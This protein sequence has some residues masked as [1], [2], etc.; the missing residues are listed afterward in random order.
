MTVLEQLRTKSLEIRKDPAKK[1]LAPSVM[2]AISEIEKIGKNA[3]N[4]ATTD[5]EAIKVIQK[6]IITL[7]D[8]I[9]LATDTAVIEKFAAEHDLLRGVLPQMA[10]EQDVR[11]FLQ[12]SYVD[13]KPNK[14]DV[15]K[16]LRFK[17]GAKI[18]MKR[19]GEIVK[20]LYDI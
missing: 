10:S 13:V 6:I 1:W 14:G 11:G 9:S 7:E 20:E 4:R 3:G 17:F 15:M 19:A 8:N 16:T 18:D 12:E 2:F 5:D